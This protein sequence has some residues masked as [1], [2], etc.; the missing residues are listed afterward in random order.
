MQETSKT[1]SE[2]SKL[3]LLPTFL[4][5]FFLLPRKD[6]PKN[7][8]KDWQII[9]PC[10]HLVPFD[11]SISTSVFSVERMDDVAFQLWLERKCKQEL[12]CVLIVDKKVNPEILRPFR[13]HR[14]CV[15]QTCLYHVSQ[16]VPPS[17]AHKHSGGAHI[18]HS[19]STFGLLKQSVIRT[20]FSLSR[21]QN[22]F[23]QSFRCRQGLVR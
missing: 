23:H 1:A 16:L 15:V 22:Y 7:S 6:S 5:R 17:M 20:L 11:L 10:L 8:L 3:R 9:F 19:F 14:R 4:P 2:T 21:R 13:F 12:T 18:R